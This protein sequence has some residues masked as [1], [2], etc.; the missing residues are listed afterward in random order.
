MAKQYLDHPQLK[1]KCSFPVPSKTSFRDGKR[2]QDAILG[3][4]YCESLPA[5]NAA[6]MRCRVYRL[7]P[8]IDMRKIGE[9]TT[10]ID[11][12]EGPLTFKSD[13]YETFFYHKYGA[14]AY[15]II[16]EEDGLSGRIC[17][18]W[19]TLTDR[20][21]YPPKIDDRTLCVEKTGAKDYLDW[22]FRRGEPVAGIEPEKNQGED[23]LFMEPGK[24]GS[25]VAAVVDGFTNLASTLITDAKQDA[26]EARQEA[27]EAR[28]T[29][30]SASAAT[31][32]VTHAAAE[33]I[34]LM[35]DV[36]R[37]VMKNSNAPDP[38][39]LFSNIMNL[40]PKPPDPTPMFNTILSVVQDS[41]KAMMQ[42]VLNQN[43][44]LKQ[45]IA[46]MR[47]AQLAPAT[48]GHAKTFDEELESFSRKAEALGYKRG[49]DSAPAESK[50]D[51][52]K[53]IVQNMPLINTA[54]T[55]LAQMVAPIFRGNQAPA[56]QVMPNPMMQAQ[57]PAVMTQP[58]APP[59]P[60]PN[61]PEA[62]TLKFLQEFEPL[63]LAH[64]LSPEYNG[65]T[66]AL[67]ILTERR[68]GSQETTDGRVRYNE[69]KTHLGKQPDGSILLDKMIRNYPPIWMRAQSDQPAYA[70]FL[71]EFLSYD[72]AG[73]EA[74][75]AN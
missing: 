44:E 75:R 25:P 73:A 2:A 53:L 43:T 1:S 7:D 12:W 64:L 19:F 5:E 39:A 26:R 54:I 32:T 10:T 56:P 22:R 58:Q 4:E 18:I 3:F 42:M 57:P 21:G 55:A 31:D 36:T 11:V 40:L 37:E 61:S 23:D 38:V 29:K 33:G 48:N 8:P 52:M 51:L 24:N 15:K 49:G 14:G 6:I 17:D 47:T 20:E 45:E 46:A 63:F 66:L 27:K 69:I 9:T 71:A 70:K 74:G 65:F 67:Q 16:V 50:E 62:R 30:P 68:G 41:N 28:E 59:Q 35:G 34:K 13:E 60:D 72:D